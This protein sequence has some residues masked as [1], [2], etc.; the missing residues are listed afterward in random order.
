MV[1]GQTQVPKVSEAK[2]NQT[3][4]ILPTQAIGLWAMI[5]RRPLCDLPR[6]SLTPGL[7]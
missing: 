4:T 5:Y 3:L 7:H 6:S 1:A 2:L